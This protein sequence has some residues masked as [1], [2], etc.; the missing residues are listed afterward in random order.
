MSSDRTQGFPAPRRVPELGGS[1][2]ALGGKF[3]PALQRALLCP[4]QKLGGDVKVRM[5]PGAL[6]LLGSL[7]V[8]QQ[9][10]DGMGGW[11]CLMVCA[12]PQWAQQGIWGA[13][14]DGLLA[15]LLSSPPLRDTVGP[16]PAP[17]ELLFVPKQECEGLEVAEGWIQEECL[18]PE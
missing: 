11:N 3:L 8:E 5:A 4:C 6:S 13:G 10:W 2:K 14:A 12:H 9:G 17:Q 15:E 7:W 1:L 18:A 16:Q